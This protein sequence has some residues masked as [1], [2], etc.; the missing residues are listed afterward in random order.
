M[1]VSPLNAVQPPGMADTF[2]PFMGIFF[3]APVGFSTNT[4]NAP[5]Q[6]LLNT[7]GYFIQYG[8]DANEKQFRERFNVKGKPRVR[9][10]L[11]ELMEPTENLGVYSST[12]G[13]DW[14]NIT[15]NTHVLAENII[16]LVIFPKLALSDMT[17]GYTPASLAPFYTYESYG[18][19]ASNAVSGS[20]PPLYTLN[21]LPPCVQVTMIAVD[22]VS[23]V[24]F[25]KQIEQ[26]VKGADSLFKNSA[27][28]DLDIQKIQDQLIRSKINYR[29]FS[30]DV[31]IGGAKWSSSST[32]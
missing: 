15:T 29:V 4:A 8:D 20:T 3:Q 28:Y 6:N 5:L 1:N 25:P 13:T 30:T 31:M 14:I 21:Q 19:N 11:M 9:G 7:W 16:G 17:N 26:I 18:Q 32:K 27:Y 10:R 22:E 2:I 12:G 23:A 24:R